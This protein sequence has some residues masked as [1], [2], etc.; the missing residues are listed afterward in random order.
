MNKN[1]IAKTLL[2]IWPGLEDYANMLGE[3][4][5]THAL[6]S[7]NTPYFT[8]RVIDK[9]I[10]LN[11][12]QQTIHNLAQQLNHTVDKLPLATQA[13][14]RSYYHTYGVAQNI[15]A[16]AKQLNIAER[17]FYRHLDRATAFIADHLS[18]IGINFFTWQDLLHQHTWIKETFTHQ[19]QLSQ[20][21][22]NV[23][24]KALNHS[25]AHPHQHTTPA[26]QTV[27]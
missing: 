9:I 11:V 23:R 3:R 2:S 25:T 13:V 4:A 10:D 8:T 5:H 24:Q 18:F 22:T 27:A 1:A 16:Q 19:C 15:P 20:L 14:I 21:R 17:T 26:N 6:C 12:K 7:C